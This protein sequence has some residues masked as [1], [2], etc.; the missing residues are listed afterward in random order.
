MNNTK[1]FKSVFTTVLLLFIIYGVQAQNI[2]G[3]VITLDFECTKSGPFKLKQSSYIGSSGKYIFEGEGYKVIWTSQTKRWE[4]RNQSLG[5]MFYN[6]KNTKF[7][8]AKGWV[9]RKGSNSC[10][11][12]TQFTR[13]WIESENDDNDDNDEKDKKGKKDKK[14][15]KR[16]V[17][18][19]QFSSS[20]NMRGISYNSRYKKIS[21]IA[22]DKRSNKSKLYIRGFDG[23][24]LGKVSSTMNF[25]TG[26]NIRGWSWDMSA[27]IASYL[28]YDKG[29]RKILLYY[30][31]F[32][33]KKL[34]K[35]K[36]TVIISSSDN[37]RGWYWN[38]K[39]KKAIHIVANS[40]GYTHLYQ[41]QFN[42]STFTTPKTIPLNRQ[43]RYRA[44]TW[45]EKTTTTFY[46]VCQKRS[47][48][49]NA[50]IT[51]LYSNE[52]KLK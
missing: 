3:G 37:M 41:R 17:E 4:I 24:K 13:S 30:R 15:D 19:L 50:V 9:F 11:R 44:W 12:V 23:K 43:D 38:Y 25:S 27:K 5:T 28:A 31:S 10:K 51:N 34:G 29:K 52:F 8:P 32:D 36:K 49:S 7:P 48:S 1:I 42:G 33:G 6:S 46:L 45:D 21:Y 18:L 2:K 16:A 40:K 26:D 35:V 39:T 22:Y 14:D 47:N 20:D